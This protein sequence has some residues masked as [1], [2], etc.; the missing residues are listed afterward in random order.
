MMNPLDLLFLIKNNSITEKLRSQSRERYQLYLLIIYR[1]HQGY[2]KII[3]MNRMKN[4]TEQ[5]PT[6]SSNY[7]KKRVKTLI[8]ISRI[9]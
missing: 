4:Y 3:E 9:P 7:L 2:N 8:F 1:G 5:K 6:F